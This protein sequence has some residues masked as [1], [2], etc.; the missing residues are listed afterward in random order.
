MSHLECLKTVDG[1]SC[2]NN[3]P[4][5]TARVIQVIQ[6]TLTRRGTG[7]T[8]IIRVVTQY[9]SFD[10]QLLWE[11]DPLPDGSAILEGA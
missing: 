6:T 8:S 10:G 5:D 4:L 2:H 9:W 3:A 7:K 1:A 11:V